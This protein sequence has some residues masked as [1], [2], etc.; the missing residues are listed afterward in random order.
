MKHFAPRR[1]ARAAL[2]VALLAPL[3]FL[4]CESSKYK[5]VA[6]AADGFALS[7]RAFQQAEITAHAQGL[8]ADDEHAA[9]ERALAD[10]AR[11]GLALDDSIHTAQSKPGATQ[12]IDAAL[13]AVDRLLNEGVL[14]VKNPRARQDLQALVLSARGFLA[15]I[16]AVFH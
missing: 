5:R 11:A 13:A 10:V 15:T 7:V 9:I 2:A 8:I 6:Q 3:A 1:H 14:H 12:A 16:S 4:G